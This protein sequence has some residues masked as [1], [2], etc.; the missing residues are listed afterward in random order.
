M[1]LLLLVALLAAPLHLHAN[2]NAVNYR[3]T[4]RDLKGVSMECEK[5]VGSYLKEICS[6]Q[7][8]TFHSLTGCTISCVTYPHPD[9]TVILQLQLKNGY[10]CG[11]CQVCY[12]GRCI[13]AK[14]DSSNFL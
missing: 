6:N 12:F 5:S 3:K 13:S 8:A 14:Y 9:S 11:Q 1:F 7:N 10:P 2:A 4:D